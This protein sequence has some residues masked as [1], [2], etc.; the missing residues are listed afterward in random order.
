MERFRELTRCHPMLVLSR[1]PRQL[2]Q[3][4]GTVSLSQL[5]LNTTFFQ[6]ILNAMQIMRP[7]IRHKQ[8]VLEPFCRFLFEILRVIADHHAVEFHQLVS[9]TWEFFY[10][11]LEADFDLASELIFSTPHVLLLENIVNMYESQPETVAFGEVMAQRHSEWSLRATLESIQTRRNKHHSAASQQQ[12]IEQLLSRIEFQEFTPASGGNP[13]TERTDMT[14]IT[15]G[16]QAIDFLCSKTDQGTAVVALLRRC[17]VPVASLLV[18]ESV[19]KAVMAM[20]C[21]SL[22]NLMKYDSVCVDHVMRQYVQ[23]LRT[24]RPGLKEAA[25]NT[26]LEFLVFADARQRRQILQQLFDDSSEI[27]KSKLGVYLKSAAFRT[28]LLVASKTS[29]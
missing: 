1:F 2:M 21:Q 29:A 5:Y 22:L 23:C 18:T 9:H 3:H 28:T 27:A 19:T 20:V 8:S 7:H 26:V 16:L 12:Q 14:T 24:V 25:V 11:A 13:L 10:D 4:F 15:Q 17:A 6:N